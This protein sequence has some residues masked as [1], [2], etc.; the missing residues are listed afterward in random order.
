MLSEPAERS[1]RYKLHDKTKNG[2]GTSQTSTI[3][4]WERAAGMWRNKVGLK[5]GA[6]ALFDPRG[7][8]K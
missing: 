3:E 5:A 7:S 2:A 8:L 1:I 6:E 4:H